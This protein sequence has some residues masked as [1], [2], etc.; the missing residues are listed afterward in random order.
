MVDR[1]APFLQRD[2]RAK[3]L[4]VDVHTLSLR[5]PSAVPRARPY[6]LSTAGSLVIIHTRACSAARAQHTESCIP[7]P[8]Q[9]LFF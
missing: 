8:R 2:E 5:V 7:I 9:L 4:H 3:R 1:D 6:F